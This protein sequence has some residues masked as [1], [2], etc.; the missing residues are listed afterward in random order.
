[1]RLKNITVQVGGF[2][3]HWQRNG[4]EVA[5]LLMAAMQYYH[6]DFICLLDREYGEKA[7]REQRDVERWLPG[8]RVFLGTEYPYDWGHMVVVESSIT[9]MEHDNPNWREEM[10]R[11]HAGGGFVALA[12]IG[13]P[14]DDG[15]S[16]A[17]G[18]AWDEI[19]ENDYVDAL[20]LE[21]LTDWE[22]VKHRAAQ[23]EKLPLVGGWDSHYLKGKNDDCPNLYDGTHTPDRHIDT[24][25]GMRTI[26][27]ADDNSLESI[28]DA[29][30]QGKSV[31]EH[32][33][34]GQLFGDP[35]LV[36]LLQEEGY[37]EKVRELSAAQFRL[38]LENEALLAYHPGT[39]R[40]PGKGTVT[41]PADEFFTP[42]EVEVGEDGLLSLDKVPMPA[43]LEFSHLPFRWK[44][45]TGER[46]WAVKVVNP[47]Q[48]AV[49]PVQ[50]DGKQMLT[51]QA[52]I[53]LDCEI[54]VTKPISFRQN[55]SAKKGEDLLCVE[56]PADL[57]ERYEIALT[58]R[59]KQGGISHF[60]TKTG[61]AIAKPAGTPWA[62]CPTYHADSQEQCGGFG[63]NRP[64][65]G[66]DVF[67]AKTQFQWDEEYLYIR[68]EVIDHVIVA[69]PSG[70][71]MYISDCI[72]VNFDTE[73]TRDRSNHCVGFLYGFPE[74]GPEVVGK[75]DARLS[76]EL[77]EDGYITTVCLPWKELG[78]TPRKGLH[79][80]M[81]ICFL[82]DEGAGAVDNV[83]WP[84]PA[85]EGRM[86]Q[87]RDYGMICLE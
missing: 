32:V 52:R 31:L 5:T 54:T 6:Y 55:C 10:Q 70:R 11:L 71:F 12:H 84:M 56:L 20:Q 83:H 60:A 35:A 82:N 69:P 66:K 39:L 17:I 41:L 7:L 73:L 24:A 21:R 58:V 34:T 48:Y 46:L 44:G 25:P 64:Y 1:M 47:V 87:T 62:E 42:K 36:Q 15:I 13:Y 19:I 38:Q 8:K 45:E 16:S 40:F 50:K 75:P 86:G 27:F 72:C 37:F 63:N 3:D 30:R 65:P 80:G 49:I 53:D 68:S 74:S 28:R 78:V 26:V 4:S 33:E 85:P 9:H 2:H 22:L 76:R 67:S 43:P 81:L 57:P 61:L 79:M 77:T 29:I 18:D 14:Y 59:G 51:V 23:G